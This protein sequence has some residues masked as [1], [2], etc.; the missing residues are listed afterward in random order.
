LGSRDIGTRRVAS[1]FPSTLWARVDVTVFAN[2]LFTRPLSI[3]GSGG[4]KL[5]GGLKAE[6]KMDQYM[7]YRSISR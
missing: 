3:N 1:G 7:M 5:Y 2:V 4:R 6:C